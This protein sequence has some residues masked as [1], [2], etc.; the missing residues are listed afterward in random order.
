MITKQQKAAFI[1]AIPS[2]LMVAAFISNNFVEGFN[3]TGSDFLIATVLLF[4]TASFIYMIVSSK[5]S[6][7][8]KTIISIVIILTL[9]I[10]W[11]EMAVGLFGSPIAG[12]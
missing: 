12:N 11:V 7:R 3:W 5:L 6:V 8:A 2:L 1:F 9:V 4:G 10:I